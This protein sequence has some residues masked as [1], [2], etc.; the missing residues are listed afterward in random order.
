M[1]AFDLFLFGA[2]HWIT[3]LLLFLLKLCIRVWVYV[4]FLYLETTTKK[5]SILWKYRQFPEAILFIK[6]LLLFVYYTTIVLLFFCCCWNEYTFL[7]LQL[8]LFYSYT[9][10]HSFIP[11]V[12]VEWKQLFAV[13]FDN[14]LWQRVRLILCQSNENTNYSIGIGITINIR[15][16]VLSFAS[17][18][19]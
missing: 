19:P 14:T 8:L 5:D 17:S 12:V 15:Q 3:L 9:F 10:I 4:F 7:W 6:M 16:Q 11:F 2:M 18:S 13:A 1:H